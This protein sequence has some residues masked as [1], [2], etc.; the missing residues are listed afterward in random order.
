MY[1]YMEVGVHILRFYIRDVENDLR[2]AMKKYVAK[3][4]HFPSEDV[5]FFGCQDYMAVSAMETYCEFQRATACSV[6]G[7]FMVVKEFRTTR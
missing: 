5:F 4:S 7:H 6:M 3:N 1:E 2:K